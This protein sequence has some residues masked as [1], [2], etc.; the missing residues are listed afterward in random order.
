MVGLRIR[1]YL[2]KTLLGR[3]IL[4][5]MLPV[6]ILQ[7]F[8]VYMFF[9]RHW[10]R[11]T[12]RLAFAVAGEVAVIANSIEDSSRPDE[13]VANILN[14]VVRSLDLQVSYTEGAT[15]EP[16]RERTSYLKQLVIDTLSRALVDQ[17]DR[18][19]TVR[20]LKDEERVEVKVQLDRGVLTVLALQRRLYSSSSYIFLMWMVSI[21]VLLTLVSMVFLRNQIRPIRKLAIAATRFGKGQETPD[22]KPEGAREV[23]QAA[24]A[25]LE[26]RDRIKRQVEQRTVMLA[27]VSH[28]MR[29]PITRIKLGLSLLPDSDDVRALKSDVGL[30]EQMVQAYLDFVRGEAGES[31]VETNIS[32]LL[33]D[34]VARE[35]Q[36]GAQ[37]TADIADHLVLSVRPVALTRAVENVISNARR[38]GH[39]MMVTAGFVHENLFITVEDDGP[40]I[41]DDQIENVFKPFMRLDPGRTVDHGGVGLGLTITQDLVQAHGGEIILSR[42]ATL[43][44]LRVEM[45]L[46]R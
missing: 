17:V 25:F 46:P 10:S 44:G 24:R 11:M 12:N 9:D 31:A 23:R 16:V 15:L 38:Y 45:R 32:L 36:A 40:G 35:E 13:T 14:Y 7:V 21:S 27:G 19:F 3:S 42:S 39:K 33:R 1:D 34:L 18:P 29:T 43:G 5:V 22:F 30:M 20:L 37:V 6:L 28:D 2:P 4:I 41:A 8:T 26:M